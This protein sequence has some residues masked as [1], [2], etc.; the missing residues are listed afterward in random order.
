M[1]LDAVL[2]RSTSESGCKYHPDA[3]CV[4]EEGLHRPYRDA[5]IMA[6]AQWIIWD[7]QNLY[8]RALYKPPQVRDV[9]QREYCYVERRDITMAKLI[10]WKEGFRDAAE[11]EGISKEARDLALHPSFLIGTLEMV[12]GD[13]SYR[14]AVRD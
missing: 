8:R 3:S 12:M 4:R 13:G 1:T 11:E 7:G 6:A 14:P 5:Y 9:S 10:S 2:G